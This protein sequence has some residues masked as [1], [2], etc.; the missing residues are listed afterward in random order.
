MTSTFFNSL[1]KLWD[2]R[3]L[4]AII[5]IALLPRFVAAV[6]SQGYAMHDD[7][8]GPIEQPFIIMHYPDYWTTRTTPHGHS[9]FYP[10]VHYAL[11]NGL[12][13]IGIDDPQA[14]ML[15][16]RLLHALYSLLIV[17]FGYKIAELLSNRETARKVGLI[18]ALFWALP[19]FGVRNLI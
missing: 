10:S 15:I 19:F 3:P 11:F 1:K 14:T 13:A 8:F 16:V 17:Y 9:I 6:W 18:L 2:Q 12:R 7:H 5:L 4:L